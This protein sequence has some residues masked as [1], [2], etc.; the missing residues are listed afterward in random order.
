MVDGA[1]RTGEI[2]LWAAGV[3]IVDVD[4]VTALRTEERT[5]QADRPRDGDEQLSRRRAFQPPHTVAVVPCLGDNAG[6]FKQHAENAERRIDLDGE[7]G[8]DAEALGA[9]AI[10][11][12]DT[13]FGIKAVAAHVPFAIG[14]RWAG[15]GIGLPHDTDNVVAGRKA[16]IARRFAHAAKRFVS[17]D[18]PLL[19]FRRLPVI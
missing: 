14:A 17:E 1:E 11:T 8:R 7:L 5:K 18:Q 13:V 2:W 10:A 15:D 16:R 4:F 19:A 6:R 12:L 9:E 3:V